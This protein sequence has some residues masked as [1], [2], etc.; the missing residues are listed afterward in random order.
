[1]CLHAHH[2]YQW[3]IGYPDTFLNLILAVDNRS[4]S[5]SLL[6]KPLSYGV[7]GRDGD[8]PLDILFFN[9]GEDSSQL[10]QNIKEF[11]LSEAQLGITFQ[12]FSLPKWLCPHIPM[13]E[14]LSPFIVRL[15]LSMFSHEK[16]K[17]EESREKNPKLILAVKGKIKKKKS[18]LN[19][20]AE[21][22]FN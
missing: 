9:Y 13:K 3:E 6:Q 1:M 11:H 14:Q 2:Y 5:K 15:S 18:T 17:E 20:F 4:L 12:E 19:A 7:G 16:G 21:K 22:S 8:A 10:F